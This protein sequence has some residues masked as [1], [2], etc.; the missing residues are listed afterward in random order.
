MSA[1]DRLHFLVVPMRAKDVEAC[2]RIVDRAPFFRAYGASGDSVCRDMEEK[3]TDDTHVLRVAKHGDSLMGFAWLVR[4]AGFGRSGY[5][6][7]LAV[8]SDFQ[9]QGVG[10]AL[11]EA[12]EV[13]EKSSGG[14]MLLV[15]STNDEARRFYEKL[16]YE[17]VGVLPGYV[18][19][20]FDE[21]I[22]WK[23]STG[24]GVGR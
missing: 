11:M 9:G 8:S 21:C 22:Y 1:S 10:R 6:R 12:V 13:E 24:G 14:V 2:G 19:P 15:T 18:K 16:G 4:G 3:L 5:L 7:F 20:S 23:P 17:H